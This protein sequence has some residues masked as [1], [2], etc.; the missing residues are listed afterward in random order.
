MHYLEQVTRHI[1]DQ[2]DD[3]ITRI[4]NKEGSLGKLI[5]QDTIYN[6]LE[7]LV[8]DVRQHPWKLF[9]KTKERPARK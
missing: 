1:M 8:I 5:Y 9:W 7:A 6:E 2:F 3:A 4:R